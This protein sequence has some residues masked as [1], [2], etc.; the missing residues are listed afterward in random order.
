PAEPGAAPAPA[1]AFTDQRTSPVYKTEYAVKVKAIMATMNGNAT[2]LDPMQQCK[3]LGVPRSG[4]VIHE[5]VMILQAEHSSAVMWDADPG[6]TY[7][8]IYTDGRQHPKD[9][10]TSY[11]GHSIG[12]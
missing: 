7:R 2:P 5:H 8:V 10:D 6:P 12:H 9:L 4:L 11:M 3:P 1:P